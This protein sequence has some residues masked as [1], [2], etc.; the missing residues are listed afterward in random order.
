VEPT[1][2]LIELLK[3]YRDGLNMAIRWAVEEAKAKGRLPTLAE[4]HEALYEPLKALGLSPRIAA[5][6][7]RETLTI[8]KSFIAK[9]KVPMAKPSHI[10]LHR[11]AYRVRDSY[12]YMDGCNAPLLQ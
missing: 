1:P 12:I 8:V 4:I 9:G 7:H 6:S 10:R 5:K 11:N 3:R 2:E